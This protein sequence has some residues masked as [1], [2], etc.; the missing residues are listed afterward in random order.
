MG[1]KAMRFD[2]LPFQVGVE[3]ISGSE[4]FVTQSLTSL[5]TNID[6]TMIIV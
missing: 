2:E 6:Q 3:K 1:F 5:T 4:F